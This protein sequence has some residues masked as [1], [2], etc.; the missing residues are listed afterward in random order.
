[1]GRGE[2]GEAES[3]GLLT[4]LAG[5]RVA[6][7]PSGSPFRGRSDVLPTGR[8][9]Y[10]IDPRA[11]PSRAAHAQGVVLAEE[12][13]RRHLQDHGDYPKALV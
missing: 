13:I 11:V 6:P 7:G 3:R 5:Q 2:Y 9:L 1:F 10:T 4:A 12:L 8:N